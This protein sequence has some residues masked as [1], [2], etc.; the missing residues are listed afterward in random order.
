VPHSQFSD[1]AAM[2]TERQRILLVAAE[3]SCQ[4]R[5]ILPCSGAVA[6]L[7]QPAEH[8]KKISCREKGDNRQSHIPICQAV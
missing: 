4:S 6:V 5:S 3:A 7:A 1:G 8:C 2:V